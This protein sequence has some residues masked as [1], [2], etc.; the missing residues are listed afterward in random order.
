MIQPLV[1]A[2][3]ALLSLATS[4]IAALVGA[5]ASDRAVAFASERAAERT[6]ELPQLVDGALDTWHEFAATPPP[7][8]PVVGVL[9]APP[10][11]IGALTVDFL[12]AYGRR[13]APAFER[14]VVELEVDGEWRA[15]EA[16]ASGSAAAQG[17][18]ARY[19]QVGALRGCFEFPAV[20]ASG[21][22]VRFAAPSLDEG[23]ASRIVVVEVAAHATAPIDAA[24]ALAR[25][26]L[27]SGAPPLAFVDE[28]L[29]DASAPETGVRR[30]RDGGRLE[31]AW[32]TARFLGEVEW[33]GDAAVR[34]FAWDGAAFRPLDWPAERLVAG[35]IASDRAWVARGGPLALERLAI[36]LPAGAEL[37]AVRLGA[38]GAARLAERMASPRDLWLE[39]LRAAPRRPDF[40]DVAM[41]LLPLPANHA[42]LGRVGDVAETLVT[43]NGT[44]HETAGTE[45]GP[46]N[47]GAPVADGTRA[48]WRMELC[49]FAVDGVLLGAAGDVVTRTTS[50]A[51]DVVT[52]V[53]RGALT[54]RSEAFVP[55]P[56]DDPHVRC[57]RI[58]VRD[59]ESE[60]ARAATAA[61]AA[62]VRV[63]VLLPTRRHRS[64]EYEEL[65]LLPLPRA[66]VL[67]PADAR[68]VRDAERRIVLVASAPGVLLGDEREP[69]FAVELPRDGDRFAPLDLVLPSVN[70]PTADATPLLACRFD[71]ARERFDR[72]WAARFGVVEFA[73][74]E[75]RLDRLRRSLTAQALIALLDGARLKYGA[76]VYEDYYGLEEGWPTV[77]LAQFGCVAEAQQAARAMVAPE[78]LDEGNYHHP[79]RNGLAP[80]AA[81]AVARLAP[82]AEFVAALAPRAAAI[83]EW[84]VARRH[85]SDD[86]ATSDGTANG[87]AAGAANR[88]E[89]RAWRG[90]LPKHAY[91][92]DIGTPARSLYSNATCWQG[93][94]ACAELLERAG[95]P[96]RAATLRADAADF[97]ATLLERFAALTD[98]SSAPPFVPMAVDLG[99]PGTAGYE[100]C[101]RAYDFLATSGRGS[102][103]ALFAPLL[104]ETGVFP[105]DAPE[106][107][108]VQ[109]FLAQRGGTLLG[110]PRFHAA[111]DAVY[112]LGSITA[113][114]LEGDPDEFALRADAYFAHALDREVFTG[115]E[116]AGVA[117]LR[118]SPESQA[119]RRAAARWQLDLYSGQ[120]GQSAF[121]RATGSEPL[122]AAA[123]LGLLLLRRMVVEELGPDGDE[124]GP[125]AT[126]ELLRCAPRRWWREGARVRFALPTA[127]GPVALDVESRLDSAGELRARVTP[128]P[129]DRRFPRPAALRLWLRDRDGRPLLRAIDAAGDAL[130]IDGGALLLPLDRATTLSAR[131][132]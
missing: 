36:E 35:E 17:A 2:N 28:A 52:T 43:W 127:F 115:G 26:E 16:R 9:V 33:A 30:K 73:T 74:P 23:I 38:A 25:E 72:W 102:Y 64:A 12:A 7:N 109:E 105:L 21:V 96:A 75:P 103:W 132:E 94:V 104:L 51:P 49:A 18:L 114:A 90:L 85:A 112:G 58:A 95:E 67:D 14:G 119:A 76:G 116:V 82:D 44:L 120:W 125:P 86:A 97:R 60:E 42:L 53:R 128:P 129:L 63:E 3:G 57:V 89:D 101:E 46:W 39:E 100:P 59:E 118:L 29:L 70:A 48:G 111:T 113:A 107:R 40:A 80:A 87:S 11:P 69:C 81:A 121:G 13:Y 110:L 122:S 92:G 47:H 24:T 117:P 31:L 71:A 20:V 84:I 78:L 32:P 123:G 98:R 5:G 54:I 79:Y 19:Q 77:A 130:P 126:L 65:N 10:R 68:I 61:P 66:L 4:C 56:G 88:V 83:A 124:S 1:V 8:E 93:L 22:R 34:L 106:R 27:Q 108:F 15:V 99:I 91:G 55:A 37:R 50:G 131:A 45:Q 41:Q 62:T 6:I